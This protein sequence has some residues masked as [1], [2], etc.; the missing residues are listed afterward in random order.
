MWLEHRSRANIKS[1]IWQ[2]NGL[3]ETQPFTETI[4]R[5]TAWRL[6]STL[7]FCVLFCAGSPL[8][9]PTVVF[10]WAC[11]PIGLDELRWALLWPIAV[12]ACR[13]LKKESFRLLR[14]TFEVPFSLQRCR[15][16]RCV[17]LLWE[18]WTS[19][20]WQLC[21]IR[22]L[23]SPRHGVCPHSKSRWPSARQHGGNYDRG[24]SKGKRICWFAAQPFVRL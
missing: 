18:P 24:F 10:R 7:R 17:R 13:P 9:F 4:S 12:P 23:T 5:L 8:A 20:D 3:T 15:E 1:R 16:D 2:A 22:P 19:C 14:R 11:S 21:C 6:F